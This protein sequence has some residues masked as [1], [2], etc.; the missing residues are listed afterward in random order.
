MET[1]IFE[2]LRQGGEAKQFAEIMA[3][4]F[5]TSKDDLAK[6]FRSAY[7]RH[8]NIADAPADAS[9]Q[10]KKQV[11]AKEPVQR[12]RNY[13]TFKTCGISEAHLQ[14][15]RLELIKEGWI[16]CDT[17][18]DD[19]YKLFTG[20]TNNT[21]ITWTKKVGKGMLLYLFQRMYEEQKISV[22]YAYHLTTIIESHFVDTDG[23]YLTGLNN[24]KVCNKHLPVVKACI[25]ILQVQ[26]EID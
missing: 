14:M 19:F 25:D 26:V 6:S 20:K 8:V 11:K 22:P 4:Y 18:A 9:K 13:T 23:H 21:K 5:A 7:H 3:A 17:Q 16:A 12:D 10:P 15:L 2:I 1:K 24:S